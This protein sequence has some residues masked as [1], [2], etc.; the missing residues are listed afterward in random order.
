MV[1]PVQIF[2]FAGDFQPLGA[3]PEQLFVRDQE[4]GAVFETD[5]RGIA[6]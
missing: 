6:P 5:Q 4:L 2:A 1:I 3:C